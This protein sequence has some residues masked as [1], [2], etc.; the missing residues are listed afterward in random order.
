MKMGE[1]IGAR[2]R[3]FEIQ[4][5]RDLPNSGQGK[6]RDTGEILCK[7]GVE[8]VSRGTSKVPIDDEPSGPAVT[9]QV[10]KIAYN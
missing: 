10:G 5:R 9:A 6:L 7:R 8:A 2:L 4:I 1:V 3:R